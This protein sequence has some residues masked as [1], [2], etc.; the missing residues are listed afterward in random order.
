MPRKTRGPHQWPW[1]S[2]ITQKQSAVPRFFKAVK[3]EIFWQILKT[4]AHS[5]RKYMTPEISPSPSKL[6]LNFSNC[7]WER[8]MT[9]SYVRVQLTTQ[10][11]VKRELRSISFWIGYKI[12]EQSSSNLP[13]SK[14]VSVPMSNTRSVK[15]LNLPSN[16]VI[17]MLTQRPRWTLQV[18]IDW[19]QSQMVGC[20]KTLE[21]VLWN[22]E[23]CIASHK[24]GS[25][26]S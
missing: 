6:A 10:Q 26:I 12:L 4:K 7:K 17:V 9:Q 13:L 14:E 1:A 2:T 5:K 20:C 25:S 3:N 22:P 15:S 8:S 19:Q 23:A 18:E 16:Q 21:F 24:R 11:T